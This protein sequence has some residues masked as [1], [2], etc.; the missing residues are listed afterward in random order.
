[1]ADRVFLQG[2]RFHGHHGVGAAE[3]EIGGRYHVDVWLTGNLAAAGHSDELADTVDYA[4]VAR[5][6]H[7]IGT[8]RR[9]RLLESLAHALA[10]AILDG[11][12]V[13]A[14]RVRVRKE[15]PPLAGVLAAA[16]GVELTR[17]RPRRGVPGDEER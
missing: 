4:A 12:P 11:F 15:Y 10:E 2:L 6:V 17:T 7:E 1:M 5:L 13:D 16:A 3:R 14:A 8:T 9:F